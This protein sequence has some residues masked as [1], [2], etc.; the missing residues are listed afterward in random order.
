MA[1]SWLLLG[2]ICTRD[3]ACQPHALL[4]AS[5]PGLP[6]VSSWASALSLASDSKLDPWFFTPPEVFL[7]LET[8][9]PQALAVLCLLFPSRPPVC[10]PLAC[11]RAGYFL[12]RP[13]CA[14]SHRVC[15]HRSPDRTPCASPRPASV[16]HQWP[17]ART[18]LKLLGRGTARSLH[19]P[20]VPGA[21]LWTSWFSPL[22]VWPPGCSW[23]VPAAATEPL[24]VFLDTVFQVPPASC[25]D[26][27]V[28]ASLLS[29]SRPGETAALPCRSPSGGTPA[30]SDIRGQSMACGAPCRLSLFPP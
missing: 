21:G 15:P 10:C 29:S 19:W 4:S 14:L 28:C 23:A 12:P 8:L 1:Q 24:P 7:S 5:D 25:S 6:T 22:P 27:H 13:S 30:P 26:R 11:V 9:G 16:L 3:L 17:E 18:R 2:S 20:R